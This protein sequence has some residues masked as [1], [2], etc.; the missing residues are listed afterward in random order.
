MIGKK[1]AHYEVIAHLGSGGMGEVYRARDTKLD[2]EVALKTLLPELLNDPERIA[3]FEREARSLATLQHA[4]V[5]SI[6]GWEETPEA[7]FLVM[8]LVE[9]E[10]LAERIARGAIPVAEAI[11]IAVQITEGLG[12]AHD[13]GLVHR[14]LKPANV[15]LTTEGQVKILDFGLA[16]AFAGDSADQSDP[17]VS[18]TLTAAMTMA[19]TILGTAA[20]MSPEQARGHTADRRADIWATGVIIYEMLTGQR[21]FAGETVS[22]TLAAVLTRDPDLDALP[23]GTPTAVRRGLARCLERSAKQRLHDVADL[24]LELQTVDEPLPAGAVAGNGTGRVPRGL[25]VIAAGLV[26]VAAAAGLYFGRQT[27]P[28][29][30]AQVLRTTIAG[31]GSN[32]WSMS[33]ISADGNMIAWVPISLSGTEPIN[34]RSLDGFETRKLP[35]TED[36]T[37]PVFSPDG[38][39]LAYKHISQRALFKVPIDGGSPQ[40]LS[41]SDL[42]AEQFD[43]ADDGYIYVAGG[44]TNI[45][46]RGVHRVPAAGGPIERV[47]E[48]SAGEGQHMHP[49]RIPGTDW[50]LFTAENDKQTSINAV[51]LGDS[52][53]VVI[54]AN[55]SVPRFIAPDILLFYRMAGSDVAAVRVDPKTMELRGEPVAVLDQVPAASM[56]RGCYDVASNGTVIYNFGTD[57]GLVSAQ[58]QLAWVES[59]NSTTPVFADESSWVQPR[60]SPDGRHIVVR[61]VKTPNCVLWNYDIA[62]GTRGRITRDEDAHNPLWNPANGNI[63]FRY[64]LGST[65]YIAE[66][67]ADGTGET[68]TLYSHEQIEY[69][70][71]SISRDGR[72]LLVDALVNQRDIWAIDLENGGEPRPFITTEFREQG[73]AFSPDTRWVAYTSNESGREEIYVVSWPEATNRL[74]ISVEGGHDAN[75][76][77]DGK[78]LFFLNGNQVMAVDVTPGA[79]LAPGLPHTTFTG[80]IDGANYNHAY[81][82]TPEGDRLVWVAARLGGDAQA[83]LRVVLGWGS[84]VRQKLGG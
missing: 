77:R 11:N 48:L 55:A 82:L 2:R 8:E 20:Y 23:K 4:N 73:P 58:R 35:G 53:R 30:P 9:G 59:D 3:R 7:R 51:H 5:A 17:S 34:L 83:E 38:R 12:A 74:Q 78:R 40:R 65:F 41:N 42:V 25:G 69:S 71:T 76:A 64:D 60:I 31:A 79:D 6:Y 61:Q 46:D 62:R 33:S 84:E 63:I 10:D 39:W 43:W 50:L 1:L 49:C 14:D 27:A 67:N 19:G 37:S 28:V 54:V 21:L 80:A 29:P 68:R 81:D 13:K 66:R 18:P 45:A 57:A 52:R 56:L 44:G 75:W 16:R 26:V 22:D 36:G 15:M 47:T 32:G 72:W 24:R 70:P